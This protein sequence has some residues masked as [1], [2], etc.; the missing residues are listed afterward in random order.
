[1][2][3]VQLLTTGGCYLIIRAKFIAK[4][5]ENQQQLARHFILAGKCIRLELQMCSIAS[6]NGKNAVNDK[7]VCISKC[8]SA[9]RTN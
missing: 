8:C 2:K 6:G 3:I 1:M 4:L 7:L 9:L 5:L